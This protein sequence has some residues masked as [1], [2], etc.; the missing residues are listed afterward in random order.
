MTPLTVESRVTTRRTAARTA[1]AGFVGA[2]ALW[3]AEGVADA[4]SPGYPL[5]HVLG[6]AVV[7]IV[8]GFVGLAV[9]QHPRTGRL[10]LAGMALILPSLL[11][12][13]GYK[14]DLLAEDAVAFAMPALLLGLVLYGVAT[15][16]AHLLPRWVPVAIVVIW[17]LPMVEG[18]GTAAGGLL[19][20]AVGVALWL[21]SSTAPASA[22][23]A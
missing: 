21:C 23:V 9:F 19:F 12:D 14:F 16:R 22:P 2:G 7:L 18:L 11:M 5:A 8:V 6:P 13:A 1:A 4:L 10:G 3:A 17:P 20:A 15:W